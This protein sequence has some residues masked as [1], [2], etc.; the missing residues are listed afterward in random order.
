MYIYLYKSKLIK[1]YYFIKITETS[2]TKYG[3]YIQ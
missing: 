1:I 2:L 3:M